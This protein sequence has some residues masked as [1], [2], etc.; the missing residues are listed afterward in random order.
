MGD[1][2]KR[3]IARDSLIVL[4]NLQVDGLDVDH[5]VK[6]RNLSVRGMMAEGAVR[7]RRGTIIRVELGQVG[8]VD[9]SVAWVQ[10][11]RFGIAF[12][13]EID[14][15]TISELAATQLHAS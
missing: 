15:A 13:A 6:T 3:Q 1:I 5:S 7:V 2:E 12:S 4:T 9:G 11:N 10:G 8:W 14:P